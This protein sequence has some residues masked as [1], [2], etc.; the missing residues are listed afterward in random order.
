MRLIP[1]RQASLS[2]LLLILLCMGMP[3]VWCVTKYFPHEVAERG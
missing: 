3:L 1:C 2:S